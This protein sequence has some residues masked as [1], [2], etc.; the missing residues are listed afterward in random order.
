MDMVRSGSMSPV[1]KKQLIKEIV[2][3]DTSGGHLFHLLSHTSITPECRLE[4]LQAFMNIEN[5]PLKDLW[6]LLRKKS[7]DIS[8]DT[9]DR[10]TDKFLRTYEKAPENERKGLTQKPDGG[11]AVKLM[12]SM[13]RLSSGSNDDNLTNELVRHRFFFSAGEAGEKIRRMRDASVKKTYEE[14]Q[15][16]SVMYFKR[17]ESMQEKDSCQSSGVDMDC[18]SF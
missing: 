5:A 1:R 12:Q 7:A 9:F 8:E 6:F 4:V 16:R 13:S 2:K 10:L 11:M 18:I 17:L 14:L 15:I 3:R